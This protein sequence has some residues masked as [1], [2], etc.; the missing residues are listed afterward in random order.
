LYLT[1][2]SSEDIARSNLGFVWVAGGTVNF[3]VWFFDENGNR[4]NPENDPYTVALSQTNPWDQDKLENRFRNKGW[5]LPANS[6]VISAIIQV[7]GAVGQAYASVIDNRTNDPIFIPA[8]PA[9]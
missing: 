3:K 4:L 5:T 9:P 6:R 2:M 7:E 1:G 8:V